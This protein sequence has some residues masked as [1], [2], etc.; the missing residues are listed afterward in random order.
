MSDTKMR[1]QVLFLGLTNRPD[2]MDPALKRPG[3][4]DKKIPILI[5]SQ[6]ERASIFNVMVQKYSISS[7][8]KDDE[9][10]RIAKESEGYTG[11]ELEALV[12][13]AMEVAEDNDS[14]TLLYEHVQHALNVY[15]PTTQD[16]EKMTRLALHEINDLD[17]L[18]EEWKERVMQE[19]SQEK[20]RNVTYAPRSRRQ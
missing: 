17:L 4:F 12:L 20:K 13:K 9:L 11:A 10:S 1:G 7:G 5:P 16:I 14:D 3:R 18:P 8:I 19:R 6:S 2:L 15:V